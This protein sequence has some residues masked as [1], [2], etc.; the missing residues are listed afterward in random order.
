[1]VNVGEGLAPQDVISGGACF[2][3]PGIVQRTLLSDGQSRPFGRGSFEPQEDLALVRGMAPGLRAVT[4][5]QAWEAPELWSPG[6]ADVL[7]APGP[8]PDTLSISYGECE[9]EIR[10]RRATAAERA[11]ADLMDSVL[12]RLGLAGVAAFA[13]AGDFGSTCNGQPFAGV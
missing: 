3:L 9:A 5:A 13:S 2:G 10:G 1:I 4:Y 7:V 6:P 12:V 8:L 11:G